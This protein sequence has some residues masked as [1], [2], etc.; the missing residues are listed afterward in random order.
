MAELAAVMMVVSSVASVGATVVGGMAQK[1]TAEAE[2]VNQ[3]NAA[4]MAAANAAAEKN[5]I[6]AANSINQARQQE[7]DDRNMLDLKRRQTKVSVLSDLRREQLD[8]RSNA[9][10]QAFTRADALERDKHG[11]LGQAKATI[12][13]GQT[14]S[15][16]G[17]ITTG[18][19]VAGQA[20]GF[21]RDYASLTNQLKYK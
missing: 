7:I 10:Y 16:L 17:L 8:A 9:N 15:R 3:A 21:G 11:Y 1:W 14:A 4:T 2:A 18:A 19:K 20:Y 13:S 6:E 12:Q 5:Q